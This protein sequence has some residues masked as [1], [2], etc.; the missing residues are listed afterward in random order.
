MLLKGAIIVK[1]REASSRYC[2]STE[3]ARGINFQVRHTSLK[4]MAPEP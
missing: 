1:N 4:G 3:E 2:D